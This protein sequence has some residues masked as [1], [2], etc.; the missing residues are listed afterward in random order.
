MTTIHAAIRD[1]AKPNQLRGKQTSLLRGR[2]HGARKGQQSRRILRWI[3]KE[4]GC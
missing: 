4:G 3:S 1:L 2:K